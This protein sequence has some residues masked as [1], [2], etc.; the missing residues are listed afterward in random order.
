MISG[1]GSVTVLN[2]GTV[3]LS[4]ASNSYQG[5][6]F[7]NGGTLSVAADAD[8]GNTSGGVTFG[9]GTPALEPISAPG[10]VAQPGYP[11]S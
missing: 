10:L 5:G 6:T 4:N 1:T 9:G 8:L 3:T 7:L 2:S 11:P